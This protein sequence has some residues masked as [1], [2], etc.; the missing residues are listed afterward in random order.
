MVTYS[1]VIPVFNEQEVLTQLFAELD[2]LADKL[3]G[4]SEFVLVDD[5]SAD[6]SWRMMQNRAEADERFR[7]VRLSR[8]FGH[9]IAVSAG[10]DHT[11]GDAVIIMDA[12]LQDPPAVVLEMARQWRAGYD[13]VYG[14][15]IDRHEDSRFKRATAAGFYR[16]LNRLSSV[17]L[18][19]QVGDFRL[20]DR[21][22]V[23]AIKRMPERNRYVRGMF[24]WLGF[25]QI[26]VPYS[27]PARNAGS[28][29]Y[30]LKKMLQL[31]NDGVIGYSK[32][33]L[34][35]PSVVGAALVA[36]GAVGTLA[37]GV[38][39]VSSGRPY[40]PVGTWFVATAMGGVQLMA[41]G[42]VGEYVSRIF[43]ESLARPLYVVQTTSANRAVAP[44][45]TEALPGQV[46]SLYGQRR[47]DRLV[48]AVARQAR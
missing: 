18:P 4:T 30:T 25:Q 2:H 37:S 19:E 6:A 42:I 27:R 33:P 21:A 24:A 8:N 36:I 28:T 40:R 44:V 13:V 11:D 48:P 29:S 20:I 46:H 5:G 41:V 45:M 12:D 34:K 23:E 16:L 39:S 22:V 17:D 14:Q 7:L 1:F 32:V 26:G 31:A 38:V 15:R 10:L 9:Q 35:A 43:D 47:S 3:D